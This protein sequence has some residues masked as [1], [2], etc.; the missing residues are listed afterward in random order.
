MLKLVQRP[1]S[2]NWVMRGT[3]RTIRIEE[4][5][6]VSDKRI[7]QEIRAKRESEILTESVY[8]RRATAT[9]A[10]A[11]LSYLEAGG[12]KRFLAPII[13]GLRAPPSM[14]DWRPDFTASRRGSRPLSHA[15][16]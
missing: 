3:L 15:L 14:S 16:P 12:N 9:F 8:G 10:Q 11:A 13:V 2:P 1:K 5:T 7:A 4:S 6:G